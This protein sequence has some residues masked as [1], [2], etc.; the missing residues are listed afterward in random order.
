MFCLCLP[1]QGLTTALNLKWVISC[2]LQMYSMTFQFLA[3]TFSF[4]IPIGIGKNTFLFYQQG[5]FAFKLK[6]WLYSMWLSVG[7]CIFARAPV[8]F[9]VNFMPISGLPPPQSIALTRLCDCDFCSLC[10][11]AGRQFGHG[12]LKPEQTPVE[13]PCL[14]FRPWAHHALQLSCSLRSQNLV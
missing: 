7:L 5:C 13:A 6:A 9:A 8:A 10:V 2:F 3:H 1:P 4:Y 11:P 14:L 12:A